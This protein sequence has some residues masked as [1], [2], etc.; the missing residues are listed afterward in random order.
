MKVKS[1]SFTEEE[2]QVLTVEINAC[3]DFIKD[4]VY[5]QTQMPAINPID[6]GDYNSA[7]EGLKEITL[8][9]WQRGMFHY[10]LYQS[11]SKQVRGDQTFDLRLFDVPNFDQKKLG[12][13]VMHDWFNKEK[14]KNRPQAITRFCRY[15]KDEDWK[16]F[17]NRFAAQFAGDNS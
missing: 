9:D 15:G 13:A 4:L 12:F 6:R 2:N 5:I 8:D 16:S 3:E 7:P 14:G 17:E 10:N 11:D 1:K